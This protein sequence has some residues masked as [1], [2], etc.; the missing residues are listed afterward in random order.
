MVCAMVSV[1]DLLATVSDSPDTIRFNLLYKELH[2]ALTQTTESF[3]QTC[4]TTV[5][6][7]PA[8]DLSPPS[9]PSE[10]LSLG[11]WR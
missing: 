9:F 8:I 1:A 2:W 4:P 6:L 3:L 11:H 7:L 5:A 10:A